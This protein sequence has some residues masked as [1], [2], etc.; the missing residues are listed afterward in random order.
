MD[1]YLLMCKR[2]GDRMFMQWYVTGCEKAAAQDE[3]YVFPK[4][5]HGYKELIR[6]YIG[7]VKRLDEFLFKG[8]EKQLPKKKEEKLRSKSKSKE[9][10]RLPSTAA[11]KLDAQR[12]VGQMQQSIKKINQIPI[13][14]PRPAMLRQLIIRSATVTRDALAAMMLEQK[15]AKDVELLK[16]CHVMGIVPQEEEGKPIIEYHHQG[17]VNALAR[18]AGRRSRR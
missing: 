3:N 18:P 5:Y 10:R 12:V 8:T 6:D 13:Y 14:R 17:M 16:Y 15:Q 11:P 2:E 9:L 7:A 4:K 1:L